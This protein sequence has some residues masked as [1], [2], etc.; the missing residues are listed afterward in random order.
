MVVAVE[1]IVD[2][3]VEAMVGVMVGATEAAMVGAIVAGMVVG[4]GDGTVA[5]SAVWLTQPEKIRAKMIA[6]TIQFNR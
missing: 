4:V 6:G 5:D 3:M 2:V 1:E